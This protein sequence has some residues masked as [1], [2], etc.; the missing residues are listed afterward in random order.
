MAT[1]TQ[2][3]RRTCPKIRRRVADGEWPKE[4]LSPPPSCCQSK[5]VVRSAKP[6]TSAV[7]L[8]WQAQAC[9]VSHPEPTW[10]VREQFSRSRESPLGTTPP[11]EAGPPERRAG[12]PPR[13]SN[14]CLTVCTPRRM[15]FPA[16]CNHRHATQESGQTGKR[17]RCGRVGRAL[18]GRR[19]LTPG[20]ADHITPKSRSNALAVTP[21][22]WRARRGPSWMH[23]SR[24]PCCPP[25][26]GWVP[27]SRCTCPPARLGRQG[28]EVL[29]NCATACGAT[30]AA[31]R[32]PWRQLRTCAP[33]GI[34]RPACRA[35][36]WP[37]RTSQGPAAPCGW[38]VV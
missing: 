16:C 20:S 31:A 22:P 3:S 32:V 1:G 13:R 15:T 23:Q 17:Q 4:S 8:S 6:I 14:G 35:A 38:K 30:K 37:V 7:S 24:A 34:V 27:P 5:G 36:V 21:A 12:R 18:Q 11:G 10:N 29:L 33:T 2:P 19:F 9:L 26:A 28:R 25:Q